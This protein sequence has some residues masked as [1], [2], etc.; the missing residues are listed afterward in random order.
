MAPYNPLYTHCTLCTAIATYRN[1]QILVF[2]TGSFILIYDVNTWCCSAL[3]GRSHSEKFSCEW[4]S[5]QPF[6]LPL[7]EYV[8][9]LFVRSQ[10][11]Q[12]QSERSHFVAKPISK[13]INYKIMFCFIGI[14]SLTFQRMRN[15][16]K[17]IPVFRQWQFVEHLFGAEKQ[18]A[19]RR[20]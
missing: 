20:V 18:N 15:V 4:F 6:K 3:K 19:W 9:V 10:W 16:W 1:S 8:P 14:G 12:N 7:S 2:S 11:S 17:R 13:R 5:M